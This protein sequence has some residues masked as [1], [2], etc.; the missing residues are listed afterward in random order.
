MAARRLTYRK[1]APGRSGRVLIPVAAYEA[2]LRGMEG[3]QA[4]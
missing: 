1:N 4:L 2:W 3:S